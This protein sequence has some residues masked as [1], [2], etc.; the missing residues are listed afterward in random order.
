MPNQINLFTPAIEH[1]QAALDAMQNFS[2][3]E[4]KAELE[5]ALEIDPYLADLFTLLQAVDF[6][7]QADV[8]AGTDASGLVRAWKKLRQQRGTL[9]RPVSSVAETTICQ[10]VLHVLPSDT[11]GFVDTEEKELHSGACYLI[12]QRYEEAYDK[13]LYYLTAHT[14]EANARLWGYFGD[15]CLKLMRH[16]EANIG[17]VR[18]LFTDAQVVDMER[19]QQQDLKRFYRELIRE[20]GEKTGKARLPIHAW[21]NNVLTIPKGNT[22]LAPWLRKCGYFVSEELS[23]PWQR[24]QA[25]ALLLYVDRSG[26]HNEVEVDVRTEMQRLDKDLFRQYLAKIGGS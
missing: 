16:G 22:W 24:C 11:S 8:H 5:I 1:K 13:L 17:Y 7:L 23:E 26:L 21:M 19:L 4:A 2:F 15:A 14:D 10:R 20:F 18:A 3:S 6:L 25:F 12:L 9:P